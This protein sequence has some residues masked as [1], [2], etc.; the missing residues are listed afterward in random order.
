MRPAVMDA[1]GLRYLPH[2]S[3]PISRMPIHG[4]PGGERAY[5]EEAAYGEPPWGEQEPPP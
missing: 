1:P 5:G 4:A 3:G 2:A